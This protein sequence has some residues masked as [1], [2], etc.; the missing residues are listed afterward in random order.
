[1]HFPSLDTSDARTSLF[2]MI[3]SVLSGALGLIRIETVADAIVV[4]V[5]GTIIGF[6]GNKLLRKID[7]SIKEYKERNKKK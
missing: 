7:T 6:Y 3:S 1:M 5:I 2:T 4:A